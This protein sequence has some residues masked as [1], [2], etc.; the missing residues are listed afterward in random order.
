MIVWGQQ[1]Q[2]QNVSNLISVMLTKIASKET[3]M[4]WRS[5][6]T[7][8]CLTSKLCTWSSSRSTPPWWRWRLLPDPN[9]PARVLH[10]AR[11][12]LIYSWPRIM[13]FKRVYY[14]F[15]NPRHKRL[16]IVFLVIWLTNSVSS[17]INRAFWIIYRLL[18]S[19]RFMFSIFSVFF[20]FSYSLK[21][22]ILLKQN[23]ALL[24]YVC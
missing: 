10:Y 2:G 4:V 21:L 15:F 16:K 3:W 23:T 18:K 7:P 19:T 22:R 8:R 9:L 13:F 6:M 24:S 12:S 5:W 17:H 11:C 14:D 20:V 1:V